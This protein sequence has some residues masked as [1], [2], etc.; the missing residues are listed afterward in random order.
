MRKQSPQVSLHR[1]VGEIPVRWVFLALVAI[2]LMIVAVNFLDWRFGMPSRLMHDLFY[3]DGEANIPTWFSSSQLL[4][5]GL[6]VGLAAFSGQ[7]GRH[8]SRLF[9][10]VV[11]A[12][13]VFL[14]MDEVA[15]VHELIG[16]RLKKLSFVPSFQDSHG[17]WILLYALIAVGLLVVN[18]RNLLACWTRYRRAAA[19]A[20]I[21]AGVIVA[22]AIGV[23]VA[24]YGLTRDPHSL[25]Y[26]LAA[27]AEEFFEMIGG[28]VLLC[29]ALLFLRDRLL[30]QPTGRAG[31]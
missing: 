4:V 2:E 9:F 16:E 11:A 26:R 27:S 15:T 30:P 23:E 8:P 14:S 28:T 18:L 24:S 31:A 6:I 10:L 20:G 7:T 25:D 3:L 29:G 5:A 19:T 22:G 13:A 1:A 21:G 17:A 12:G